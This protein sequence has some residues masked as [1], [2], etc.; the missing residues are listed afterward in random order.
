M[1]AIRCGRRWVRSAFSVFA[2]SPCFCASLPFLA[3]HTLFGLIFAFRSWTTKQRRSRSQE[4]D[5]GYA[6]QSLYHRHHC[7][8][9]QRHHWSPVSLIT[10][11]YLQTPDLHTDLRPL[12]FSGFLHIFLSDLFRLLIPSP[13]TLLTRA[14]QQIRTCGGLCR[15]CAQAACGC[16]EGWGPGLCDGT[17]VLLCLSGF[18]GS[19]TL[20]SSLQVRGT[21]AN[22]NGA[23]GPPAAPVAKYQAAAMDAAFK[24]AGRKPS[25]VSYVEVHAT[26]T[27]ALSGYFAS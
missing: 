9:S 11:S 22:N 6:R 3:T 1:Q 15:G 8:N 5:C 20:R 26:G 14:I 18:A 21:A 17:S 24:R 23:G 19:N 2:A 7:L 27:F 25:E 12:P 4:V 16:V 13:R 10:P